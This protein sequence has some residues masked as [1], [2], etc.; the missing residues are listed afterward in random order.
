MELN[1]PPNEKWELIDG[2]IHK[3]MTGGSLAHN[4]IVVNLAVVLR[5]ELQ[6][7]SST[8]RVYTTNVPVVSEAID[9]SVCP[10]I[11]VRCGPRV[12]DQK[13]MTDPVL[14]VE[15][16]SRSTGEKDR[17]DK[18]EAYFRVPTVQHYLLVAQDRMDLT[19]LTRG[20]ADWMRTRFHAP[21]D[22]AEI[23]TL[24]VSLTLAEI[25][26]NVKEIVGPY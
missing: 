7:R 25:Y 8:C 12:L 20:E 19:V 17:Y 24:G 22:V 23:A 9:M 4:E 11:A 2:I 1:A 5:S 18:A 16:L 10:D 13:E 14:L 3:M 6:A 26:E 21:E 15:V